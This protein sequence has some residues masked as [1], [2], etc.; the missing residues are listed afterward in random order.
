MKYLYVLLT[1]FLFTISCN[2]NQQQEVKKETELIKNNYIIDDSLS[3]DFYL[4]IPGIKLEKGVVPTPDVAVNIA[5]SVWTGIYGKEIVEKE[6]PFSVNLEND[7]W[8]VEGVS[9]LNN[10]NIVFSG[11]L[12]IE[13]KKET[14]E[15]IKV[16]RM[17]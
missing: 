16:L 17:K 4:S 7:V 13:I 2:R 5:Q 9:S 12:Y 8:L 3:S 1:V 15:I 11:Q 6:K 10:D 14:G